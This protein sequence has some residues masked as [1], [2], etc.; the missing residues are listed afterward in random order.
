M[1]YCNKKRAFFLAA[2]FAAV[3][4]LPPRASAETP[5]GN[6]N[7]V[8]P[9]LGLQYKGTA[10]YELESSQQVGNWD[11]CIMCYWKISAGV[12]R[13]PRV[14]LKAHKQMSAK[15]AARFREEEFARIVQM[16][17]DRLAYPGAIST[18]KEIPADLKPTYVNAGSAQDKV[19]ILYASKEMNYGIGSK[20][21]AEY[22][23]AFTFR[24]CE[25]AKTLVGVEVFIPL[26]QFDQVSALKELG[27][28]ICSEA[29][30]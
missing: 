29:G 5:A 12:K 3:A 23:S 9:R 16:F 27:Q 21:M 28:F 26:K 18:R 8:L 1:K 13:G 17:D 11:D 7:S 2:V 10:K 6:F 30:R 24:Y 14:R 19:C 25:N 4:A 22:R 15:E 20:D